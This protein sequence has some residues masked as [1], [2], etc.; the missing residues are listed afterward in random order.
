MRSTL[1]CALLSYVHMQIC[2][3][4]VVKCGIN[5]YMILVFEIGL[6]QLVPRLFIKALF[7]ITP[8]LPL[9]FLSLVFSSGFCKCSPDQPG[10]NPFQMGFSFIYPS[11]VP[12]RVIGW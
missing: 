2:V 1:L 7:N 12:L 8:P 4:V 3:G 6:D 11:I 10:Q 5:F 9:A